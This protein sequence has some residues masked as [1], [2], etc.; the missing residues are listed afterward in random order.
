[1]GVAGH[2]RVGPAPIMAELSWWRRRAAASGSPHL[3]EQ[4]W[5]RA[6]G[7]KDGSL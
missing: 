5:R 4:G 2:T 3:G 1:M 6:A 7:A